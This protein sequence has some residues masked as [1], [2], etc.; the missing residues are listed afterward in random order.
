MPPIIL[1]RKSDQKPLV[2]VL[3]IAYNHEQYIRDHLDGFLKQ[4]IDFPVEVIVHDDASTDH[5]PDIIREYYEKRPDLFHVILQQDNQHSQHIP[6]WPQLFRIAQGKYIAMCEGDDFWTN[7][8]KL[9]KQF[10]FMEKNRDYVMCFG[11]TMVFVQS[12]NTYYSNHF[13]LRSRE[14]RTKDYLLGGPT[15]TCTSFLLKETLDKYLEWRNNNSLKTRRIGDTP[16]LI[17]FTTQGK[18]YYDNEVFAC[19]RLLNQSASHG[20]LQTRL[21]FFRENTHI[22]LFLNKKLNINFPNK[23]IMFNH[24]TSVAKE[25][26]KSDGNNMD[27]IKRL[28]RICRFYQSSFWD[29]ITLAALVFAAENPLIYKTYRKWLLNFKVIALKII[30]PHNCV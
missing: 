29:R 2:S 14:I 12:K 25:L 1:P 24:I 16:L 22:K 6:I 28:K 17:F 11:G 19:Y 18:C 10:D 30:K 9:Q 7:P 13:F 20:S 5:T 8:L 23:K 21:S 3:S 26:M 4:K 15:L 27:E